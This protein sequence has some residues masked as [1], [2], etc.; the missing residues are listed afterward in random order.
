M[1]SGGRGPTLTDHDRAADRHRHLPVHRYRGLDAARRGARSD[2]GA[3]LARHDELIRSACAGGGAEVG[4]EGDSFFAVFGTAGDAVDAAVRVQR[5]IAAEPWTRGADV[6]VRIGIHTGEAVLAAGVYVGMDVHRA[7]RIMSAAHGG[8][9]LASDAT[10]A[11]VSRAMPAGT[12]LRDLGEH[13]LKDLPAPERLYQVTADDLDAEFPPPRTIDSTPNNLPVATSALVGR[14]AELEQLAR[15]LRGDTVRLVTLTGPGGIGKTR[16]AVQAA[17]DALEHYADGVFF[18]DLAHAREPSAV[19]VEIA[20]TTGLAV[21]GDR[22]LRRALAAHLRPRRVLLVLD[23]FEQVMAAADDAAE[24]VRQ[25]PRLALLVTS[26]EG[27]RVRGEQLLPVPPLSLS[28][29]SAG[30]MASAAVALFVER[31]REARPSFG[32]DDETAAVVGEICARL[33]GLPLAIELAAARLRLFSPAEL[34]D[35]LRGGLDVLRTGARDLP[36]RQRTL[37]DTIA[38]SYDLLDEDDRALFKV[39]AVFPSAQIEDVEVVCAGIDVLA[40]VDVVDGLGSLVDKSLLRT[41]EDGGRQRL[42]MLE[43]IHEYA[44]DELQRDGDLASAARRTHAEHFASFAMR[45]DE[46]MRGRERSAAIAELAD[47]LDN[48]LAAWRFH[49]EAGDLARVKAM[50]DPLWTLYDTNGW[51]HAAIG[52][53]KDLLQLV[54]SGDEAAQ[55]SDKAIA[56]RLTL[57]RLLLAVE[58]YTPRVEDLYRDTLEVASSAGGLPHQVPVLRSLASFHLQVGR[59]DKVA[60][61]GREILAIAEAEGDDAMRIEGHVILA[62]PTAFMGDLGG[63]IAEFDRAIAL[64]DPDRHGRGAL[65]VGPNPIVVAHSVGALFLWMSGYPDTAQ[66]RSASSI[67]LAERLGH[68]YSLAY[69]VFHA[70]MLDLWSGRV[71]AAGEHAR[72]VVQIAGERDYAVWHAGGLIVEGVTVA[73]Q[74]RPDDGLEL[75]DRGLGLYQNLRTPPVFWPQVLGLRAQALAHAG[76]VAE[77]LDVVTEAMRVAGPD[78]TMDLIGLLLGRA[79][80]Q[81]ASG[82]PGAAAASLE[83]GLAK[84]RSIGARTQELVAALRLAQLDGA[85]R[86][87]REAVR[88]VYETFTEGFET[89][90][91]RNARAWVTGT[92]SPST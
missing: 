25:C 23:N 31:G 43:T 49:V 86:E 61:I 84:A 9:I 56:L 82:A 30:A 13:R 6:K 41:S 22:D 81:L 73:A 69:A 80:L 78:D 36:D 40:G 52:V 18:V 70:A 68:P 79:D 26:R 60:S 89:P 19:L 47:E 1:P 7:A 87:R 65:R 72:R 74:G 32:L 75:T 71:D 14:S 92:A 58:G 57:A 53:T 67:A 17:S 3:L 33:D 50:L 45:L 42:S 16:L 11:L 37:R 38:W 62:P 54:K 20:Q 66:R 4:T 88:A 24:L 59:M 10:R 46:R 76:R 35:R 63:G 2:Y 28:T 90:P 29:G 51:Y 39:L 83:D 55:S 8:Q 5:A 48:V 15:L 34:R 91:L 77:A 27:L 12:S 85:S 21:P 64:F 44:S